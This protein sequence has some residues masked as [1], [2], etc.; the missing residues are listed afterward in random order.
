M[1]LL[2]FGIQILFIKYTLEGFE[3]VS[4]SLPLVYEAEGVEGVGKSHSKWPTPG[5][6][7]LDH[8]NLS[9]IFFFFSILLLLLCVE[10]GVGL[11][12]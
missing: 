12:Y 5:T 8:E 3:L 2:L 7:P 4:L 6:I 10:C 11:K 1:P 9:T